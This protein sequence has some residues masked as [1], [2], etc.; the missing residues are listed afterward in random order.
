MKILFIG[1]TGVISHACSQLCAERRDELYLLNRGKSFRPI[2][3][4]CRLLPGDIHDWQGMRALIKDHEFD[5]VVDWIAYVPEDIDRDFQLFAGRTGQYVFI[6]S[7]T[8]YEKP[9]RKLPIAETTPLGNP[10]WRYAQEKIRCEAR[11][12]DLHDQQRFPV[13][14]V[15]PSHTYDHT[16]IPLYGGTA[17]LARLLRGAPVI[18]QGDGTSLWTLTHHRDFA[19]AFTDL[20]GRKEAVGEAFHITSDE[21]LPWD[22][23]CRHLADALNVEANILHIPSDLIHRFDG[24]GGE[25]LLGDKSHSLI[26]DNTKI[27]S[28][29]GDFEARIPFR[30]GAR[31]IA[32]WYTS[33]PSRLAV[34]RD[35]ESR[36][37]QIIT[38]YRKVFDIPA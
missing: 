16:K 15:R 12:R 4:G 13:T 19:R 7:A 23:I 14:I 32:D 3:A 38:A 11:A 20:L 8:V 24:E 17:A 35:V 22:A 37:E 6:S 28:L 33:D 1:G 27:K 31:E 18:I 25:G 5:S 2:P 26:F 29:V 36:M 34:D 30:E 10:F 9:P 21:F